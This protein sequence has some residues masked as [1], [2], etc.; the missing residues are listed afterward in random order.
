MTYVSL[1]FLCVRCH[2]F[3][4]V[5]GYKAPLEDLLFN[6]LLLVH[7]GKFLLYISVSVIG[8]NKN[9][10]SISHFYYKK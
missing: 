9:M 1:G 6:R 5:M 4:I 10:I 2:R 8:N 7:L 3:L